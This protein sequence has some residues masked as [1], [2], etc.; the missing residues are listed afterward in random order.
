MIEK[1]KELRA[2]TS[3]GMADCKKAL[4]NSAGDIQE[5]VK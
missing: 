3:A 1:I 4:E 2:L 5:A